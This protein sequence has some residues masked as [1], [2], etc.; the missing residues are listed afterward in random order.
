VTV[1]AASAVKGDRSGDW[2]SF[3]GR[4]VDVPALREDMSSEKSSVFEYASVLSVSTRTRKRDERRTKHIR[5]M[6]QN[7]NE[8]GVVEFARLG[9]LDAP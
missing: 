6:I 3:H 8:I 1:A 2:T 5:I 7:R 4:G 9:G